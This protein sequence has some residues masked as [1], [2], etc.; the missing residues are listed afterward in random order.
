MRP[1]AR[2]NPGSGIPPSAPVPIRIKPGIQSMKSYRFRD[3]IATADA[4]FEAFGSTVEELF[5]AAADATLNVMLKDI[6]SVTPKHYISLHFESEDLEMLL[7]RFLEEIIFYKDARSFFVRPA[8]VDIRERNGRFV[9]DALVYAETIDPGKHD[10]IVDV[11]AVT[12]HRF[13][14]EKTDNGWKATVV[15]DT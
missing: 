5:V 7:Y 14:V 9:L 4:A 12:L 11:K 13:G 15:L 3:D 8:D 2:R 1:V 6:E 10:C